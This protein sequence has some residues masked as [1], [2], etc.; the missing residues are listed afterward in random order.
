VL[1]L[2][3][4][5][6]AVAWSWALADAA[7]ASFTLLEAAV[8]GLATASVYLLD[9]RLDVTAIHDART[10][11]RRHAWTAAH[12]RAVTAGA[13]ATGSAT[14]ILALGLPW[15][16]IA[17]GLAVAVGAALL[18]LRPLGRA[19][20]ATHDRPDGATPAAAR[21][22]PRGVGARRP[23]LRPLGV[24]A[25]F[26]AGTALPAVDG[27]LATIAPAAFLLAAVAALNVALIAGWER[28]LDDGSG[29][30]PHAP[31]RGPWAG[32]PSVG[33]GLSLAA[34]AWIA[35]PWLSELGAALALAALLLASLELVG[36]RW[37]AELR[38]LAADGAL[39][40]GLLPLAAG[41]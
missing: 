11:T 13:L 31:R 19:G 17:W 21:D 30:G 20:A 23:R 2:D 35:R 14:G 33:T 25:V 5:A 36:D 39:L 41:A 26:A 24:G 32:A 8:V 6:V 9:R 18:L 1:S 16:Q 3:A 22:R 10:A 28:A 4:P 7:G 34:T 37:P 12:A 38:H 40:I 27:A 15:H 29:R